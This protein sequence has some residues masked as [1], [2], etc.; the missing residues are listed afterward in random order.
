MGQG[1][2]MAIGYGILSDPTVDRNSDKEWY[3][4]TSAVE[5]AAGRRLHFSSESDRHYFAI[6]VAEN[7]GVAD[8]TVEPKTCRLASVCYELRDELA[9]AREAWARAQAK[10]AELGVTLPDGEPLLIVDYD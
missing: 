2:Y 7:S 4:W 5:K 1:S 8:D 9:K 10:S 3:A 6:L